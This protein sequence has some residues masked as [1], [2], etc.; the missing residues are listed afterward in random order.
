M[1]SREFGSIV[2]ATI[3]NI[4]IERL[5]I[6][7]LVYRLRGTTE[8]VQ[9]RRVFNRSM[10]LTFSF[11]IVFVFFHLKQNKP[12][13][14]LVNLF[15]DHSWQR[16]PRR[17]DVPAALSSGNVQLSAGCRNSRGGRASR[18]GF[19]QERTGL[20]LSRSTSG[21]LTFHEYPIRFVT[22]KRLR[23]PRA[24]FLHLDETSN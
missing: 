15:S 22:Q 20:G 14:S 19:H 13:L 1:I 12:F 3:K 7:A 17:D 23:I 18:P 8:L 9:V 16:V 2:A 4:E 10:S 5:P 11:I 21:N 6:C 24:P